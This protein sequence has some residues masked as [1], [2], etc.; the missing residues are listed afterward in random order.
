MTI[1]HL[2]HDP[3]RGPTLEVLLS[4]IRHSR[5]EAQIIALSATVGNADEMAEW[6]DSELVVSEWRPVTLR[7]G[8]L[9]GLE[10]KVHRVDGP[11]GPRKTPE[12]RALEGKTT[13]PLQ[14]ILQDT[15][16]NKGQLLVFV[17]SRASAQKE[18]RELS[19][20][21]RRML[22]DGGLDVSQGCH[23][24]MGGGRCRTPREG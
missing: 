4:R 18:A 3:G 24:Q 22:A 21:I 15:I 7:Y 23:R 5:P 2:L 8:T 14:A 13:R 6:L 11:K 1:F 12:A 9:T 20:H 16:R 10:A 17:S 19:K